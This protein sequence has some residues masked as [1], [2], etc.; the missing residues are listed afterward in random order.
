MKSFNFV[1]LVFDFATT[2]FL[3]EKNTRCLFLKNV[4]FD[5]TRE[6]ILKIFP[7]A[8]EIRFP[9]RTKSPKKG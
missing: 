1:P 6:E 7:E 5:A 2:V 3:A 4:P 8:V 9:G